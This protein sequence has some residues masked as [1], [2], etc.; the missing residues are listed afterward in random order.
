MK[1]IKQL[2][3][4]IFLMILASNAPALLSQVPADSIGDT[5]HAVINVDEMT[6]EEIMNLTYDQLL[7]L[8]LETLLKICNKLGVTM[9]ELLNTKIKV[10]SS[11]PLTSRESPSILSVITEEEIRNSGARDIIDV[12]RMVPGVNFSYDVDGVIGISFRGMWANEGKMLIMVDGQ[13]MN[14]LVYNTIQFG[15][16]F[17][18]NEIKRIEMIRGPGSAMYGGTAELGV[19]NIITK[20][21]SDMNGV[22]VNAVYGQ[23]ERMRGR[24]GVDF[25]AGK[26]V[27]D[28]NFSLAGQYMNGTNSDGYFRSFYIKDDS[29]ADFRNGGSGFV[30][31]RKCV[32]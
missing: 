5:T 19:I 13:E 25:T 30:A 18:L 4:F 31:D 12:L 28:L 15:S 16:R 2:R 23:M 20:T 27:K 9:D 21:G 29:V 10:G 8:P 14:E 26:K 22:K 32:V 11:V 1:M 24:T 3:Y 7:Q 17:N 6:R